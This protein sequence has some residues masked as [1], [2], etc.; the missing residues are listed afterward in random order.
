MKRI[1]LA[2]AALVSLSCAVSV[3]FAQVPGMG[4]PMVPVSGGPPTYYNTF[5]NGS[6]FNQT[7]SGLNAYRAALAAVRSGGTRP[8]P[9]LFIG[10]STTMGAGSGTGGTL[11]LNGAFP[12]SPISQL[13]TLANAQGSLAGLVSFNSLLGNQRSNISYP[14]YDTR[15]TLGANWTN[16]Q[17]TLGGLA[18]KYTNGAANN[19]A[20]TPPAAFDT[21]KL[22]Y[23]R[24]TANGSFTTNVDGGASLGTINT[25]G[26]NALLSQTYTV[27][28]ATH[29]INIVPNNDAAFYVVAIVTYDST[30]KR[31]DFVQAGWSGALASDISDSS[32]P[33][34]PINAIT[35]LAPSLCVINLTINNSNAATD[36]T[37]YATQMTTI[38]AAC[39]A[40]GSV[41]LMVGAPSS[42][43]NATNGTLD[44]YVNTLRSLAITYNCPL[45]DLKARWTSYAVTNAL[46]PY[47]DTLHPQA[48]GYADISLALY[49][50]LSSP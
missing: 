8:G 11:N 20:F 38:I 36:L 19:L 9:V 46:M 39:Q 18:F 35:T 43:A 14:T 41:V 37:T 44:G 24:A 45:L 25:A 5:N 10:D 26:T 4:T 12:N 15:V 27:A 42:T 48:Q 16:V 1:L 30:V 28:K 33:W 50:M 21:I 31:L 3:S 17:A 7:S 23:I 47:F 34:S 32:L 2:L 49:E 29:T 13:A 40:T 22:Y 6:V